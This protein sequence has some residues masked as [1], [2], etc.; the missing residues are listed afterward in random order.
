MGYKSRD[1]GTFFM[2]WEDFQKYFVIVDFCYIE[3]NFH[4]FYI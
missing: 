3:D 1:D 2:L 4:Y